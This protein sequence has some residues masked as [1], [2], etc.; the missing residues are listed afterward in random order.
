MV[1]LIIISAAVLIL[2]AVILAI[3]VKSVVKCSRN[4]V[5]ITKSLFGGYSVKR[6]SA[7]LFPG[8]TSGFKIDATP[9]TDRFNTEFIC[10]GGS[11]TLL[12]SVSYTYEIDFDSLT[13]LS[14]IGLDKESDKR[15]LMN[16]VKSVISSMSVGYSVDEI[17]VD[18]GKVS[19]DVLSRINE[20]NESGNLGY[21]LTHLNI[22]FTGC[23]D[24]IQSILNPVKTT[25][26]KVDTATEAKIRA[27]EE[28]KL[29]RIGLDKKRELDKIEI[30]KA[31]MDKERSDLIY[32]MNESRNNRRSSQESEKSFN[33][34]KIAYQN[35]LEL[36]KLQYSNRIEKAK[37]AQ[38]AELAESNA[39]KEAELAKLANNLE[40]ET[41]KLEVEKA[42]NDKKIESEISKIK[43]SSKL[44]RQK[45]E[46]QKE[47]HE[48]RKLA[49]KRNL[50]ISV[51][52]PAESEIEKN[53]LLAESKA[54]IKKIDTNSSIETSKI[55]LE[56]KKFEA[57]E[58]NAMKKSS[59]DIE[60]EVY[61]RMLSIASDH[62]DV[63]VKWK[64][65][66]TQLKIS[67]VKADGLVKSKIDKIII[68][69]KNADILQSI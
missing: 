13:H 23:F 56:Y 5:I 3:S 46:N 65:L 7:V 29:A 35:E 37:L 47:L 14:T 48:E 24:K 51:I 32:E 10:N 18:P 49:E 8:I 50:E 27:D 28:V 9:I 52:L 1:N 42:L 21:V 33:E 30:E 58:L 25:V 55:K 26:D 41:K 36:N 53:K 62:P 11:Q 63:A 31:K 16:D 20:M 4:E 64:E 43:N 45:Y 61:E 40:I 68:N 17:S 34:S 38:D 67:T 57:S 69:D 15:I 44:E 66:E 60:I 6:D 59:E 39:K 54:E 22:D 2:I 12:V 19:R